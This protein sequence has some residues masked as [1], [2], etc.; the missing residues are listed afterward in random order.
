MLKR[1]K[2]RSSK[3]DKISNLFQKIKNAS[4]NQTNIICIFYVT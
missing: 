2:K 3:F 4:V 1:F